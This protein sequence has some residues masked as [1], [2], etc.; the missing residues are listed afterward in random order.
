MFANDVKECRPISITPD[1]IKIEETL[2][3]GWVREADLLMRWDVGLPLSFEKGH[4]QQQLN[5]IT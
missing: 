5:T 2:N 1:I 3:A 4:G